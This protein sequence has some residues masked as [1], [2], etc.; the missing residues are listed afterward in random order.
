MRLAVPGR[1]VLTLLALVALVGTG[2]AHNDPEQVRRQLEDTRDRLGQARHQ[3]SDVSATVRET[4]HELQHIDERL[5][6]LRA[7]QRR[8]E[9]RLAAAQGRYEDAGARTAAATRRLEEETAALRRTQRRLQRRE[10]TFEGRVA[11]T[12]KYGPISYADALLGVEDFG[13][14]VTTMYY[15]RSVLQTE[16]GIIAEIRDLGDTIRARRAEVDALRDQLAARQEEARRARDQVREATEQHRAATRRVARQKD[17]RQQVLAELEGTRARYEQLVAQ[18]EEE[19]QRLAEELRSSRWRAGAPGVGELVWPTD[20]VKTGDYGW[21]THPI[22]GTRRFHAGID[23]SGDIGQPIVAAAE[24]LVV[25]AGWRGGYGLAV[26]LD[27]GGG[28]ATLYA[29]QSWVAVSEGQVVEEGQNIGEM[30][31]TGWSTGPHLH[32]EVRVNGEPRDPMD[33]YR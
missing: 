21:R 13:D 29:H 20:G 9:D 32:F 23:I 17:R 31:S 22:F 6:D 15:V 4:R 11:A 3:L 30:G 19:S 12:Y 1:I 14:F 27:H 7:E 2:G 5:V 10:R 33:W 16:R 26:V 28:L 25:H 8:L 24:G 18:L